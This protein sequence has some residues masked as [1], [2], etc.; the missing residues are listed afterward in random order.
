MRSICLPGAQVA[1]DEKRRMVL[2][3][4]NYDYGIF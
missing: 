4:D 1:V 2:T 3:I